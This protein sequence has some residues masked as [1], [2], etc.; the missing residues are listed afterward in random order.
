[1]AVALPPLSSDVTL[2]VDADR[3]MYPSHLAY[4]VG[5]HLWWDLSSVH[6]WCRDRGDSYEFKNW[7]RKVAQLV[8]WSDEL[9]FRTAT[10]AIDSITPAC[11]T[12]NLVD[13]VWQLVGYSQR[14]IK[15]RDACIHCVATLAGRLPAALPADRSQAVPTT[16]PSPQRIAHHSIIISIVITVGL[17]PHLNRNDRHAKWKLALAPQVTFVVGNTTVALPVRS[18]GLI[19]RFYPAVLQRAPRPQWLHAVREMWTDCRI[20]ASPLCALEADTH[21]IT[22]VCI[23][24]SMFVALRRHSGKPPLSTAFL[25]WVASLSKA[26]V[27]WLAD[28]LE[29]HTLNIYVQFHDVTKPPPAIRYIGQKRKRVIMHPK[30]VWGLLKK[31]AAANLT[32]RQALYVVSDEPHAGAH[33][34]NAYLWELLAERMYRDRVS[35]AWPTTNHVCLS[36]DSSNHAYNDALLGIA[37]SWEMNQGCYPTMQFLV[38]G[39][40]I[41]PEEASLTQINL[42]IVV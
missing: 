1:M 6:A 13:L 21:C 35:C 11:S 26:L 34:G 8:S 7:K 30:A 42:A 23:F 29:W 17:S 39:K 18:N 36:V 38:P 3:Q 33:P 37:Y 41:Y 40:A 22:D 25:N 20:N 24:L 4:R 10:E 32:L 9:R 19:E 5:Q 14:S 27:Q 16:S 12:R 15:L 31:V 28:A 2:T